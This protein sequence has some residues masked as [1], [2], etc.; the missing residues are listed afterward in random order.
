MVLTAQNVQNV[1]EVFSRQ[2]W[3]RSELCIVSR[4][5]TVF[6]SGKP[7][8]S[9]WFKFPAIQELLDAYVISGFGGRR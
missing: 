2:K 4:E 1:Q 6:V 5:I 8:R 3:E 7:K 9:H